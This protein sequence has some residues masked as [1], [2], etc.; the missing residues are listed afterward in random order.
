[1]DQPVHPTTT[2]TTNG[3]QTHML[4]GLNKFPKGPLL[5]ES[6]VPG[7]KST[8]TARGTYLG[9]TNG[10]GRGERRLVAALTSCPLKAREEEGGGGPGARLTSWR[11]PR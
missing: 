11:K 5:I 3:E 2:T 6:M 9:R 7:S 4:S 1:M 8:R 10:A